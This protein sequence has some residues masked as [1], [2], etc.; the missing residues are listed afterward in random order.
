MKN[1]PL[2]LENYKKALSF[3]PNNEFLKKRIAELEGK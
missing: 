2:A 3:I 1:I